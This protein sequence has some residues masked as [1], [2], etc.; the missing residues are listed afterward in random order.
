[1]DAQLV[2]MNNTLDAFSMHKYNTFD[3]IFNQILEDEI[4]I[5]L[6]NMDTFI[7]KSKT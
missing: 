6:F 5:K 4:I 1:M 2:I 3:K 7:C